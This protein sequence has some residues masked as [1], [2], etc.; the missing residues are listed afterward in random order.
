[1][2]RSHFVLIFILISSQFLIGVVGYGTESKKVRSPLL[3]ASPYELKIGKAKST[4]VKLKILRELKV[5]ARRQ[6]DPHN[7]A[8]FFLLDQFQSFLDDMDEKKLAIGDCEDLQESI[9]Y[10]LD[11]QGKAC[12][13]KAPSSVSESVKILNLFCP[14]LKKSKA[15][16]C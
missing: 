2:C 7:E 13:S 12:V 16:S 4:E 14:K 9:F 11:P 5:E 10:H 3:F 8:V 15:Q 1:M 6:P